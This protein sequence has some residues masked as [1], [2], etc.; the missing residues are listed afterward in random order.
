[1]LLNCRVVESTSL[2]N[3]IDVFV[4]ALLKSPVLANL[5][6]DLILH[7]GRRVVGPIQV[8]SVVDNCTCVVD[9]D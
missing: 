3:V 2:A 6:N 4:I 8:E 1:M 9:L 5:F 7:L